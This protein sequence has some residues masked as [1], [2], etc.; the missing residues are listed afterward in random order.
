LVIEP[1]DN[2]IALRSY[3]TMWELQSRAPAFNSRSP[4]PQRMRVEKNGERSAK[5]NQMSEL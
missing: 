1:G 5:G 3:P 4:D 2:D